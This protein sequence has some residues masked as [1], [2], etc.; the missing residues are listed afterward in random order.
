MLFVII[1][2]SMFGRFGRFF[3]VRSLWGWIWCSAIF[4]GELAFVSSL[5]GLIHFI[6]IGRYMIY[7][8]ER[9]KVESGVL[10][11]FFFFFVW[12]GRNAPSGVG[13]LVG[14]AAAAAAGWGSVEDDGLADVHD[15]VAACDGLI[16]VHDS[17]LEV[18]LM[19]ECEHVTC[20][21][22]RWGCWRRWCAAS[23]L[24]MLEKA[25]LH[26]HP[27]LSFTPCS[28]QIILP[29]SF[30]LS[31][32]PHHIVILLWCVAHVEILMLRTELLWK[33]AND[34]GGGIIALHVR[35]LW[36]EHQPQP[37]AA[38]SFDTFVVQRRLRMRIG[39]LFGTYTAKTTILKNN[40]PGNWK[41]TS[42]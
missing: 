29:H 21:L 34:G 41:L 22:P 23:L 39:A 38:A 35:G 6:W 12:V 4:L 13:S 30:D 15:E 2:S 31:E 11:V 8:L 14:A 16:A 18:L 3:Q 9:W 19:T 28:A 26:L 27:N 33:H 20:M 7:V 24:M 5:S 25:R 36:G 37:M 32:W 10:N 40:I 17:F 42:K 1:V